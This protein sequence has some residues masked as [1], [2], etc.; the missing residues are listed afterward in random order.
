[1]LFPN[2]IRHPQ[3]DEYATDA[4]LAEQ[5]WFQ[6]RRDLT[7]GVDVDMMFVPSYTSNDTT[8]SNRY[9]TIQQYVSGLAYRNAVQNAKG[10]A[11]YT[12]R[13]ARLG[14]STRILGVG[15]GISPKRP[16][17]PAAA[18]DADS[19]NPSAFPKPGVN[20]QERSFW[21]SAVTL[22]ILVSP[23]DSVTKDY[24]VEFASVIGAA[25]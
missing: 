5:Y 3:D 20:S 21:V 24:A 13:S 11:S 8:N 1:V 2:P 4:N 7:P 6:R 16:A 19:A 15:V 9:P 10:D 22:S 25:T 23:D 17:D 12:V 14:N 18:D